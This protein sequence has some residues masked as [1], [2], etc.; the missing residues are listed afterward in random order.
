[1]VAR[2]AASLKD[3]LDVLVEGDWLGGHR[4]RAEQSGGRRQE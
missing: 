4:G 2:L 3:R 1:M